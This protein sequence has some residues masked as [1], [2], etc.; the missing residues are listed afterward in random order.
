MSPEPL[1]SPAR[2]GRVSPRPQLALALLILL[3]VPFLL[4]G[5]GLASADSRQLSERACEDLYKKW[6]RDYAA[7]DDE[8]QRN[9]YAAA[10]QFVPACRGH[11]MFSYVE[12]WKYRYEEN[13]LGYSDPVPTPSPV[14]RGGPTPTP[15]PRPEPVLRTGRYY[16]LVIGINNY[17]HLQALTTAVNDARVVAAEL[18]SRYGF[19]RPKL[20]LDADSEAIIEAINDFEGVL[21]ENDSLLIYYAGHGYDDKRANSTYWLPANAK[22]TTRAAWIQTDVITSNI[23]P[24]KSKHVLIVSD[25]CYSGRF[26][27]RDTNP[28]VGLSTNRAMF[29]GRM[30]SDKSR[31][32]MSSGGDQ[33]VLDDG[34]G[35]HSVFANAF[36]HALRNIGETQ[37]TAFE[38]FVKV[39]ERVVGNSRQVPLYGVLQDSGHDGGDFIFTRRN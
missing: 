10:A 26:L 24:L 15:T 36:L 12:K 31:S 2:R 16:A 29:L 33:P 34:G 5:A 39:R 25:S 32:L 30:Y 7:E 3:C 22:R 14:T 11:R 17:K 13:V 6:H 21:E 35:G 19:E 8:R 38:L 37:F 4:T 9:A 23:R 27:Y 28:T 18:E 20:L 1:P